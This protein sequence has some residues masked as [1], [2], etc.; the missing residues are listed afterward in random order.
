MRV[1]PSLTIYKVWASMASDAVVSSRRSGVWSVQ[2]D[3]A[4][5]AAAA[6]GAGSK[7]LTY[8]KPL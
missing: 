8:M 5:A 6:F 3:A 7:E 1:S 2:L 4:A